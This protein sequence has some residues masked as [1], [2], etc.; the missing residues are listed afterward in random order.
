GSRA[1]D[2]WPVVEHAPLGSAGDLDAIRAVVGAEPLARP[3]LGRLGAGR[4][5]VAV[6]LVEQR[7]VGEGVVEHA[8]K[9]VAH[10]AQVGVAERLAGVLPGVGVALGRGLRSGGTAGAASIVTGRG[11]KTVEAVGA[12]ALVSARRR[13]WWWNQRRHVNLD[14]RG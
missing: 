7:P 11:D 13:G 8:R 14:G 2:R 5:L 10:R 12:A 6:L 3:L 9:P 4:Q 1:H